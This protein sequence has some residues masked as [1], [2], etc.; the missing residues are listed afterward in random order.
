ML[1]PNNR[2]SGDNEQCITAGVPLFSRQRFQNGIYPEMD[3][4][5]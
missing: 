4:L 1:R 5:N 2:K 3:W